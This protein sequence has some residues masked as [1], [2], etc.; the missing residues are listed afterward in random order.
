MREDVE[1]YEKQLKSLSINQEHGKSRMDMSRD[2]FWKAVQ[3]INN[4]AGR[5]R[6]D[7]DDRYDEVDY[8]EYSNSGGNNSRERTPRRSEPTQHPRS[9]S[10]WRETPGGPDDRRGLGGS[11]PRNRSSSVSL[12]LRGG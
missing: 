1:Q 8:D 9:E 3:S 6:R 11:S 7:S 12:L 4:A 2:V 5:G 10:K